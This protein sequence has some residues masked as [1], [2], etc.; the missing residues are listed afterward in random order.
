MTLM[1]WV[2]SRRVDGCTC[3]M[4]ASASVYTWSGFRLRVRVR[5]RLRVRVR[6]RVSPSPRAHREEVG[7]DVWER[8]RVEEGEELG[9]RLERDGEHLGGVTTVRGTP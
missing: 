4:S 1:Q 7:R 6:V 2:C 5:V 9:G 3:L 8:A